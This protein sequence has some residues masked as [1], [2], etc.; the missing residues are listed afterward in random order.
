MLV[1]QENVHVAGITPQGWVYVINPS[2]TTT[3]TVSV[4][5]PLI[6]E[7]SAAVSE[8]LTLAPRS[9]DYVNV[10]YEAHLRGSGMDR[11]GKFVSLA[12]IFVQLGQRQLM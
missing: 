10:P 4:R 7:G 8:S 3:A 6:T 9:A 2:E 5:T 12:F 1:F 11:K